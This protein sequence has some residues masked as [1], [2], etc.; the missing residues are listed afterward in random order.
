M[1]IETRKL[2]ASL[3]ILSVILPSHLLAESRIAST[4][5]SYDEIQ[6]V[7]Q[8]QVPA[9]I[10]EIV[11]NQAQE[12]CLKE[13]LDKLK[14]FNRELENSQAGE[15]PRHVGDPFHLVLRTTCMSLRT[16]SC[17]VSCMMQRW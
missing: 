15:K 1:I 12:P 2:L 5:K 17:Y 13:G 7:L 14:F 6:A 8:Q 9:N 3:L 10:K 11:N 4:S 16:S